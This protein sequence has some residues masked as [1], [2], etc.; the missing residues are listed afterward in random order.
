[1]KEGL[2]N[3]AGASLAPSSRDHD[4]IDWIDHNLHRE[5]AARALLEAVLACDPRDRIPLMERFIEWLRPGQ[6]IAAF[7]A[8][9]AEATHWADMATRDELKAY[10]ATSF[11]RLEEADKAAFLEFAQREV[12][13]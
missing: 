10:C 4:L 12:G 1:M 8:V 6:P 11:L 3:K 9:M 5:V 2:F 7:G 13:E